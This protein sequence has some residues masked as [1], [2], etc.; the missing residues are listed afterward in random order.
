M[1][2]VNA[3]PDSFS[4]GQ[5]MLQKTEH[6]LC[7]WAEAQ[8]AMGV[9]WVDVGGESTRPGALPIMAEEELQRV[10]PVIRCLMRHFPTLQLSIDTRKASVAKAAL[11]AGAIAVNDVSALRYDGDALLEVVHSFQAG[12]ILTHS[13]GTP[14]TMTAL[15]E[16]SELAELNNGKT[17]VQRVQESLL[18]LKQRCL[19]GGLPTERL[20][21]DVGI[22]FGKTQ[23]QN[24]DLLNNLLPL[25]EA[26][27]CP[28]LVG[29]SRK[30]FLDL[31]MLPTTPQERDAAT[32]SLSHALWQRGGVWGFRLHAMQTHRHVFDVM[33]Q[34]Q[35]LLS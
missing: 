10:L 19:E 30:R 13:L 26:L 17:V 12:L 34:W 11:E 24:W 1:V 23:R 16:A 20:L 8:L 15:A 35:S 21:L 27:G 25:A 14:E 4:D 9:T 5:Q 18:L 6:E 31:P 33:N 2:I 7:H 28:T 3:T 32:A 29:I 22:G